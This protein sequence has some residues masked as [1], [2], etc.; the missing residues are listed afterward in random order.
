MK[1]VNHVV[2]RLTICLVIGIV[3]GYYTQ[4]QHQIL[5]LVFVPI[6]VFWCV[7]FYYARHAT[8]KSIL[9]GVLSY[10]LM[11]G[12]GMGVVF[13]KTHHNHA[14]HYSHQLENGKEQALTVQVYEKMKTTANRTTFLAKVIGV[15]PLPTTGIIIVHVDSTQLID[16]DNVIRVITT[17]QLISAPKNPYQFDY[18]AYLKKQ[19]IHHQLYVNSSN[20]V[21]LT[22]VYTGYGMAQKIRTKIIEGLRLRGVSETNISI[23]SALFLG[24]RQGMSADIYEQ[25]KN[26]GSLHI[27]AIS[28]LHIG[29]VML[30]LTLFFS[31][32][33]YLKHGK[34]YR[35]I[36]VVVLLWSYAFIAGMPVSAVRAVLMCTLASVAFYNT[37]ILS[38]YQV[39]VL[40]AFLQLLWNPYELFSVGFQLSYVAVLSILVFRPFFSKIW[41]PKRYITKIIWDTFTITIAV[42]IGILPL[43]LFYFHQFPGLFLVSNMLLVP[44]LGVLLS[45]GGVCLIAIYFNS[46]PTIFITVFEYCIGMLHDVVSFIAEQ[47]QYLITDISFSVGYLIVSYMLLFALALLLKKGSYKR[48]LYVL[49]A[50][51]LLQG[52]KIYTKHYFH[53][54]KWVLF[55][56]YKRILIAHK[57]GNHLE[58]YTTQ[59]LRGKALQTFSEQEHIKTRFQ[60]PFREVYQYRQKAIVIIDSTGVYASGVKPDVLIIDGNPKINLNRVIK[61]LT[62]SKIIFTISN[63]KNKVLSWEKTCNTKG[64]LHYNMRKHGAFILEE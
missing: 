62:P 56:T 61:D 15:N 18:R 21:Q 41:G 9:F 42:Q 6:I 57:K 60:K 45:I 51:C 1:G 48:I 19:Q 23:I 28:G 64:V 7:A 44:F 32:L 54:E 30:L 13:V 3:L 37:R 59:D 5:L 55:A 29:I 33:C 20:S 27:L 4:F 2:L 40:A 17:P 52:V 34:M 47:D 63:Y 24:Q 39:V 26:S 12:V 22:P 8:Q 53:K 14:S 10:V 50:V 11:I 16:I 35:A 46:A 31:P 58:Y 25:F 36:I 43:L 49:L 38:S